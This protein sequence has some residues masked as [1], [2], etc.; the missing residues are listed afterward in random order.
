MTLSCPYGVYYCRIVLVLLGDLFQLSE[1]WVVMKEVR[2]A[3]H[4]SHSKSVSFLEIES[5]VR[6]DC[7]VSVEP[8]RAS[9]E[10]IGKVILGAFYVLYGVVI[11]LEVHLYT[12]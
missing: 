5:I 6:A 9:A 3:D 2:H 8:Y 7:V 12:E 11:D 10:H 1:E 4:D